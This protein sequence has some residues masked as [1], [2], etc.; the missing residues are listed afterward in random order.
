MMTSHRTEHSGRKIQILLNLVAREIC[1][2]AAITGCSQVVVVYFVV[3]V[4]VVVVVAV[5]SAR[6]RC[7]LYRRNWCVKETL[8]SGD[9]TYRCWP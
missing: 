8:M 1:S 9:R 5:Q 7:V 2:P 6:P 3:V 4:V